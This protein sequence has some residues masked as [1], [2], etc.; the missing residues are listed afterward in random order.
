MSI[1]F[2]SNDPYI[3]F[4]KDYIFDLW[5]T[6]SMGYPEKLNAITRMIILISILGYILTMSTRIL[7]VGIVTLIIIAMLYKFHKQKVTKDI[8]NEAFTVDGDM[9]YGLRDPSPN[10]EITNTVGLK[11]LLK[12]EFKEGNKKNPFSNVLLTQINDEPNRMAAPP[13]FNPNVEDTITKDVKKAV[14]FMNPDINNTNKQLFGS[15]WENFRLD[16]SNRVFYSTPNTR[17]AND[18]TAYAKYLY[19]DMPSAKGS[20]ME[21]NIQREK[22]NYRYTLY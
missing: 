14:Q 20:S 8:A 7:I 21:D 5:P 11:Q 19:G 18:Q 3:L 6:E 4:K 2:W 16:N 15:L 17:V 1:P 9:V 10:N 13:A 22:D 12:E